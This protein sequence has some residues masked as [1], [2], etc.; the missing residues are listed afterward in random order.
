MNAVARGLALF[1]GGLTLLGVA[2]TVRSHAL[3]YDANIW[4]I[5]LP[6]GNRALAAAVLAFAGVVLLWFAVAPPHAVWRRLLTAVVCTALAGVAVWNGVGFYSAWRAGQ[7]DPRVPI[8][9]SFIVA[10]VLI[11]I[12]VC[13]AGVPASRHGRWATSATVVLVAAACAF[14]FPLAQVFFFGETDYRREANVAVVF[15]AQ[16]H[17]DGRASTSLADRVATAVDLYDTGYVD[18][19]LVSGGVGESGYDEALV[20]RDMMVAAGV[21]ESRV[22]VDGDGVNTAATVRNSLAL[23]DGE[24][25]IVA[26][27][28]FYHLPRIKLAYARAGRDVLT[29]PARG[30]LPIAQTPQLVAREIPAFWVYYLRALAG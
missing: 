26:V 1:C 9:L 29:V 8:P 27:S 20:M 30:P 19:L 11:L 17:A 10:G 23:L 2:A 7:I 12:A 5:A 6:F 3:S 13:A 18:T 28:Q 4:W 21:P 14:V 15:G 16:V 25:R 24:A 22:I